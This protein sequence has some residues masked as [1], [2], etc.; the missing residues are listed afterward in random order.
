MK[1]LKQVLGVDV[2]QKELEVT[3]GRMYDDTT[4]ELYACIV[5]S[6]NTEKWDVETF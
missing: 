4:I 5:F 2:A 1:L 6:K 3:L